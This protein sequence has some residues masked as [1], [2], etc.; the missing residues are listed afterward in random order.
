M[1]D[2]AYYRAQA[3]LCYSIALAL[4]DLVAAETT[5]TLGDDYVRRAEEADELEKNRSVKSAEGQ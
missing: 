4:S 1:S 3:E 5:V 2:A